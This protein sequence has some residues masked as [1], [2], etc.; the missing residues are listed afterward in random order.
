MKRVFLSVVLLMPLFILAQNKGKIIKNQ[1]AKKIVQKKQ[2]SDGIIKTNN[3][4]TLYF[5]IDNSIILVPKNQAKIEYY[6]TTTSGEI[7][8]LA[9]NFFQLGNIKDKTVKVSVFEKNTNKLV[10]E[11]TFVV[12]K[13]VLPF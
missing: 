10:E 5:D 7:N 8:K 9:G 13:Q 12:T 11:K 3:A 4:D 6:C 2:N 1:P